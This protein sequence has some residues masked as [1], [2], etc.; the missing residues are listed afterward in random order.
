MS[1]APASD[2]LLYLLAAVPWI[3]ALLA[4]QRGPALLEPAV[5]SALLLGATHLLIRYRRSIAALEAEHERL[6]ATDPLTRLG[7]SS[8][9]EDSLVREVARAKRTGHPLCCL[10]FDV[11]NF[12]SINDQYG[13][14]A[15]NLV[16]QTIGET[17]LKSVRNNLDL[18]FRYGGDEFLILL[19]ETDKPQA[20]AVGYR[21]RDSLAKTGPPLVPAKKVSFSMG[22]AKLRDNQR[23]ADLLAVVDRSIHQPGPKASTAVYDADDPENAEQA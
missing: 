4:G 9:L 15:G 23:A 7:N 5:S 19:P 17:M 10:F 13:H 6:S 16:L 1:R 8:A 21:L 12:K 2:R 20:I 18:A 14:T 22:V 11:N 3:L